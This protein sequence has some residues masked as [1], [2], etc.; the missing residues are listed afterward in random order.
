[1]GVYCRNRAWKSLVVDI[2]SRVCAC[3]PD[4]GNSEDGP[5]RGNNPVGLSPVPLQHETSRCPIGR[6]SA[7]RYK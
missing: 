4:S 7:T 1:M 3:M 6:A 5:F 2:R